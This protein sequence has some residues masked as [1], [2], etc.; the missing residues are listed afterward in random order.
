MTP[1]I[2]IPG[3]LC[4]A[5]IY[6][7]QIA[8]LGGRPY[9]VAD[10]TQDDTLGAMAERLL[11]QAPERFVLAGLSMGGMIA[12]EV[13]TRAPERVAGALLMDTDP[14]AA[15][16]KENTYRESVIA[17]V[18]AE[19]L[20]SFVDQF[21]PRLYGHSPDA[22]AQL[23]PAARAMMGAMPV[24]VF[25]RQSAALMSRRDMLP[26]IA[27]FAGPVTVLVGEKDVICPPVVHQAMAE[28]LPDAAYVEVPGAGH[29]PTLETAAT[30]T[31]AL[32]DLLAR[33]DAG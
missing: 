20:M 22:M 14:Y 16:D 1:V 28:A 5:E 19:G 26:L 11:A 27:G 2:F 6:A 21:T 18:R 3:H 25:Y 23:L 17:R 13:M 7:P 8:S 4:T 32:H 29:I 30:V 9:L 12:M 15:R 24:D 10:T 31:H 33:C